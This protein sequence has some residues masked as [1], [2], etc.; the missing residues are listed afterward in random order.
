MMNMV[1]II[2]PDHSPRMFIVFI[3]AADS[4]VRN[5]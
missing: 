2:G 1:D 5:G 3:L 4:A